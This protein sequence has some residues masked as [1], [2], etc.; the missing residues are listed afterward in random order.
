MLAGLEGAYEQP[1]TPRRKVYP[2]HRERL[3]RTAACAW[4]FVRHC[5][6]YGKREHCTHMTL[7]VKSD[8]TLS[9]GAVLR[10]EN[11][12]RVQ[13]YGRHVGRRTALANSMYCTWVMLVT[14]RWH[15]LKADHDQQIVPCR[16]L[17]KIRHAKWIIRLVRT[18]KIPSCAAT[19]LGN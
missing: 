16:F 17:G 19:L 12:S 11:R 4:Q 14:S 3:N 5:G 6:I 2:C 1:M 8:V 18:Q 15:R 13:S 9:S 10:R 7:V